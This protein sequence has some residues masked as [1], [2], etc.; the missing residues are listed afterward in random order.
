[1]LHILTRPDD[2]FA[3]EIIARQSADPGLHVTVSDL[4]TLAPD[5]VRLIES[6]FAAESVEVW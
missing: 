1:M 5:Y 2:E 3:R 4:T 6:I